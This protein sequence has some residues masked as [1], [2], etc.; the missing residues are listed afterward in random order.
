MTRVLIV[1]LFMIFSVDAFSQ[2]NGKELADSEFLSAILRNDL[3]TVQQM[4]ESGASV[5]AVDPRGTPVLI[6]AAISDSM[7]IFKFFLDSGVDISAVDAYDQNIFSIAELYQFA[8]VTDMLIDHIVG[9]EFYSK[10]KHFLEEDLTEY[11]AF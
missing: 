1:F 7:G 11:Q 9:V 3:N 2:D 6:I 4:V 10:P 5:D 8:H